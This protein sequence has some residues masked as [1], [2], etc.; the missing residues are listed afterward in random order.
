MPALA[1][2]AALGILALAAESRLGRLVAVTVTSGALAAGLGGSAV[3]AAQFVPVV[4]AG[5]PAPQFLR[6]KVSNFDGIVWLNRHLPPSA[7]VA[8]D[9]WGLFY[10]Q[11]HYVTFGTMGDLLPPQAGP[12]ATRA[13]VARYRITDVAI[14]DG[15]AARRRQVG[16]LH[17]RLIGTVSVRS[18]RSRTLGHFGRRHD[19][20]VY[21]I[22]RPVQKRQ[23]SERAGST[24][25]RREAAAE[26]V[27]QELDDL[28]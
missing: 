6:E 22:A 1:V 13:F 16:Y 4:L 18:V 3:Y 25:R 7:T 5:Q 9:I 26:S 14:L 15:D 10:L 28:R 19:M 2:L 21:A 20:L 17:A 8:T 12:S 23:D 24:S 27:T 11:M